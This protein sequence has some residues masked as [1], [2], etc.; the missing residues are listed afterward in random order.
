MIS[1]GSTQ[2]VKLCRT[3][4]SKEFESFSGDQIDRKRIEK[5]ENSPLFSGENKTRSFSKS[6][7]F[8]IDFLREQFGNI[9]VRYSVKNYIY[10]YSFEGAIG[11]ECEG[12][13]GVRLIEL[14]SLSPSPTP[15]HS[16]SP[17]CTVCQEI[18]THISRVSGIR[19]TVIFTII[20]VQSS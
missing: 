17:S 20:S 7:T 6:S 13:G 18:L 5:S 8:S 12:E 4:Y 15:S 1:R 11:C 10:W 3:I 14:S 9:F 2:L 19:F 16:C